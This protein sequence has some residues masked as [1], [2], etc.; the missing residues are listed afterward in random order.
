MTLHGLLLIMILSLLAMNVVV[1]ITG[2][3]HSSVRVKDS[4]SLMIQTLA[5][6][7]KMVGPTAAAN[8][9]GMR[10]PQRGVEAE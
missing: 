6:R 8:N 4:S 3:A 1:V 9:D 5:P 2:K 10:L 7:A